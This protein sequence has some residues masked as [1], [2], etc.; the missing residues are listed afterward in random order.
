MFN[1]LLKF[2]SLSAGGAGGADFFIGADF[3]GTS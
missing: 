2:A 1:L 3:A